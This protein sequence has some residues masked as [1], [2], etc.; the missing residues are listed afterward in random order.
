MIQTLLSNQHTKGHNDAVTN[1]Q[2]CAMI[3]QRTRWHN[4][5]VLKHNF[6]R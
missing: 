6:P 3:D 4:E 1:I 5:Q 2:L